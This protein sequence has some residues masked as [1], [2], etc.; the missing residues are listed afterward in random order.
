MVFYEPTLATREE[1]PPDVR[2]FVRQRTRWSQGYLQTLSRGYWRALPLRQRALGLYTL[3]MPYLM[4]IVW[5]M[6]PLAL[7]TA[8]VTH[9][10]VVLSLLSFLPAIPMMAVLAVEIAGLGEFCRSF[11]LRARARDYVRLVV[12]LPFYQFVFA[13]TASRAVVREARGV[14]AW[15]K[16]AH[17]GLHL[18][19][20]DA[21][22]E[23]G[24]PAGGTRD[25]GAPACARRTARGGGNV[26][27]RG[28]RRRGAGV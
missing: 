6:F 10:S 12:S 8:L 22:V 18:A 17:Y 23:M 25:L 4:S 14:Q 19:D 16:T 2:A 5:I 27:A 21:E 20:A 28:R 24:V 11:G 3:A 13:Y 15:E 26:V 1:T 9:V 7:L